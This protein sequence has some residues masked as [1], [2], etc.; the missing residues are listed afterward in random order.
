MI[1]ATGTIGMILASMSMLVL[2][3]CSETQQPANESVLAPVNAVAEPAL[4]IPL[5]VPLPVLR[6]R[7][8]IVAAAAAADAV[9]GGTAVAPSN[10]ALLGRRFEVRLPFGCDGPAPADDTQWA[11]WTMN[12]ESGALKLSARSELSAE[13]PW[14]HAIAGGTGFE[15]AEGF[16]MRRPWTAA[17]ACPAQPDF[18]PEPGETQTLALVQ[19]FA[20]EAPRTRQRGGRP[21]TSTIKLSDEERERPRTFRLLL[22]GRVTGFAD[23]QP[24][25]CSQS[26]ASA[27]PRCAIAV[28]FTRIAFED[29][30]AR[31]V[32]EWRY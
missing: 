5:P 4:P 10:A 18:A 6:R 25:H 16:W 3:S 27:R 9:A 29:A 22:E 19:L 23:R 14:V 7:D 31:I 21:Y 1:H 24:V 20:A 28:E 32:A 8:L 15:A 30:D 26:A 2:G 11:G 12:T 13:D 17:E